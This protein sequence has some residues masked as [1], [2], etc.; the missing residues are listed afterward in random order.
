MRFNRLLGSDL[1]LPDANAQ[2]REEIKMVKARNYIRYK[3]PSI[4]L[5]SLNNSPPHR[6]HLILTSP[7]LQY[8]RRTTRFGSSEEPIKW[9]TQGIRY[10]YP[11]RWTKDNTRIDFMV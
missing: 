3:G 7:T 9:A 4:Q 11:E 1:S 8:S 5:V 6:A 10:S 2:A